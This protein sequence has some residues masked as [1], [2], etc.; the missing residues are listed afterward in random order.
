M[1]DTLEE[2]TAENYENIDLPPVHWHMGLKKAKPGCVA[3]CGYIMKNG[4]TEIGSRT[5]CSECLEKEFADKPT[6]CTACR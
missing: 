5:I 1:N 3:F 6:F 4:H 2:L